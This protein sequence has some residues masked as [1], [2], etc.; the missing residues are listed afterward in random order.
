MATTVS[1]TLKRSHGARMIMVLRFI[2]AAFAA[3]AEATS[4]YTAGAGRV[5]ARW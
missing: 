1:A 5:K 3:R 2:H 4:R